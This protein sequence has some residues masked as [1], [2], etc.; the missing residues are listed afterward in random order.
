[1]PLSGD[2]CVIRYDTTKT[3]DCFKN[4]NSLFVKKGGKFVKKLWC[5]V[6]RGLY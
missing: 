3:L 4:E 5:C 6:D 1:M 2:C